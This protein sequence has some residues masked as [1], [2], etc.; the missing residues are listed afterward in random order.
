MTSAFKACGLGLI[1][2]LFGL[3]AHRREMAFTM[4]LIAT[5]FASLATLIGMLAFIF[6]MVVFTIAKQRI[7]RASSSND[8]VEVSAAGAYGNAIWITLAGWL[9]F[10]LSGV[11]FRIGRRIARA[12]QQDKMASEALRPKVDDSYATS[13]RDSARFAEQRR[14]AS[15]KD[16]GDLPYFA[17][18]ETVPLRAYNDP[19]EF[20]H[21]GGHGQMA[22]TSTSGYDRDAIDGV[23]MGY[24]RRAP[25]QYQD[26]MGGNDYRQGSPVEMADFRH[27]R[28]GSTY[29]PAQP[30]RSG[31]QPVSAPVCVRTHANAS[32]QEPFSSMYTTAPSPPPQVP[33]PAQRPEVLQ[34]GPQYNHRASA[35]PMTLPQPGLLGASHQSS[36]S[37]A[38]YY[39]PTGDQQPRQDRMQSVTSMYSQGEQ[40]AYD[41]PP[42]PTSTAYSAAGYYA[43][44]QAPTYQTEEPTHQ[45]SFNYFA[46][47]NTG[48]Y[49]APQPQRYSQTGPLAQQDYAYTTDA[50]QTQT[51]SPTRSP[52]GPRVPRSQINSSYPSQYGQQ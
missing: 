12:R 41:P 5:W 32:C 3:L 8:A 48:D 18:P 21:G 36:Y 14:A 2:A 46:A 19:T 4:T 45:S 20:G 24:G 15:S 11:A 50:P 44:S 39:T 9:C 23:G 42:L 49:P 16:E 31:S 13:A 30:V 10:L 7:N 17:E 35:I 28:V 22:T 51:R 38:D 25:H 33:S 37:A 40:Q 52:V 1:A 43:T 29:P 34:A 47:Q 26:S 6:D 27:S